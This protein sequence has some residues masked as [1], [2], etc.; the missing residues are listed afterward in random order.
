M[1]ARSWGTLSV[2]TNRHPHPRSEGR[3]ARPDRPNGPDGGCRRR[4][5]PGPVRP[6]PRTRR[7]AQPVR[8]RPVVSQAYRP[9]RARPGTPGAENREQRHRDQEHRDQ[10]HRPGPGTPTGTQ[11][12]RSTGPRRRAGRTAGESRAAGAGQPSAGPDR[13]TG[14]ASDRVDV[15][16]ESAHQPEPTGG[17]R[18]ASGRRDPGCQ[19]PSRPRCQRRLRPTGQRRLRPTGQRRLRPRCQRRLR[20][21]ANAAAWVRRSTPSLASRLDT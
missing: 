16:R 14:F 11:G 18:R 21:A 9:R 7:A 2:L 19:R 1:G 3:S 17:G 5:E 13:V 4:R 15:T 20:L 6:C 8:S 12:H 10:G